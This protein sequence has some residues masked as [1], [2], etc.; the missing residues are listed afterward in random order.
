[1]SSSPLRCV[2]DAS[3]AVKLFVLEDGSE[4]AERLIGQLA[5]SPGAEIHVPD[6]LYIE[7]ANILWKYVRSTHYAVTSALRDLADLRQLAFH[8][9]AT[10]ELMVDALQLA[11]AHGVTAY[12]AC[13]VTLAQR[14]GIPLVTVDEKLVRLLAGTPYLVEAL[15]TF[16]IPRPD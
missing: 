5:A 6:L 2:V 14:N 4:T 9:T 11:V 3:V 13:Y 15:R 10:S 12:D 8:A 7:C 1:M 16:P